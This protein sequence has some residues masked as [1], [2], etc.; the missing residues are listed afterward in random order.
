MPEYWAGSYRVLS[1]MAGSSTDG[2]SVALV[3]LSY[4]SLQW[5]YTL[6]EGDTLPYP[7]KLRE[8]LLAIPTL[9]PQELLTLSISYTDWTA[10]AAH[11]RF[12]GKVYDLISW[13]PHNVF[14]APKQGLSWSLGDPERLRVALGKP[15][16][17]HFRARDLAS[18]GT[19][20]PLIPNAD[21]H[22][23]SSYE[24]LLNLGGIANLT[25]LPT[26]I[27]YDVCPCNQL[28]NALARAHDPALAY[29]PEGSIA[30][31]GK[32]LPQLAELFRSH[33]FLH[34][35]H[36]KALNN[37]T[38]QQEFVRPFL[39]YPARWSDKLHTATQVIAE[40]LIEA[41]QQAKAQRFTLTGGGTH[42]TFLRNLLIQRTQEIGIRYIAAPPDLIQYR[43]AI[44]FALLGLLRWLGVPNTFS[45]WTGARKA[46]ASGT[47]SL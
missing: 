37:T 28:L 38:V 40:T 17:T 5:Q 18:G 43:E 46:H 42:N 30:Q 25:H 12:A 36:P 44:G 33:P 34:Q 11:T 4:S 1:L 20:A 47:L 3:R 15:V 26:S 35:P 19:G 27:A 45:A 2:V 13:H 32:Y 21:Q 9:S 10:Q 14:H 16:V 29:D 39:N 22:L 6:L 7:P 23:F 41:L 24:T 8:Q 31:A